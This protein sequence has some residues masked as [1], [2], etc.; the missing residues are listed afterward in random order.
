MS[1]TDKQE[2]E[3]FYSLEGYSFLQVTNSKIL[4]D[5]ARSRVRLKQ[6]NQVRYL[7]HFLRLNAAVHSYK[8]NC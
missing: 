1:Y 2:D 3:G 8:M 7:L 4:L 5:Y 6:I